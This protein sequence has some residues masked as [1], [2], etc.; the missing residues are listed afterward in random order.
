MS[1]VRI[2]GAAEE[3][4]DCGSREQFG[5]QICLESSDNSRTADRELQP[6]GAVTLD[7]LNWKLIFVAG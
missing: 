1:I 6:P 7:T 5:F 2:E 3:V 4:L